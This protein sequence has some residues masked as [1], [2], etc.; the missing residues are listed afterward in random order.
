MMI[1]PPR[2]VWPMR[3]LAISS[4]MLGFGL[5]V[6]L[7]CPIPI[8]VVN[9]P[10][11]NLFQ[12]ALIAIWTFANM[13]LGPLMAMRHCR[14]HLATNGQRLVAIFGTSL[15]LLVL[16]YTVTLSAAASQ[17]FRGFSWR[18]PALHAGIFA[19]WVLIG[20]IAWPIIRHRWPFVIQDGSSCPQCGYCVR[21]VASAICPECGTRF[22][23][24]QLGLSQVEFDRLVAGGVNKPWPADLERHHHE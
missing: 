4:L 14:A 13:I 6:S 15:G 5:F 19:A 23:H 9:W 12:Y 3:E 8:L 2:D 22:D 16:P 21:G 7:L 1:V 24:T 20:A 18:L 11:T 10:R 17:Q